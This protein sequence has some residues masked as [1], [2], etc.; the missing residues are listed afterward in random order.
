MKKSLVSLAVLPVVICLMTGCGAGAESKSSLHKMAVD[1]YVTPGD[2]TNLSVSAAPPEVEQ[3]QWDMLTLA[4]YQSYGS[5]AG[6]MDREVREGDT[7]N[8][9][10]EGRLDGIPF[11]RGADT[12]AQLTI[13]SGAFIDGFEDGLIGAVPGETRNL[14]LTFPEDFRGAE[15]AGKAVVFTVTVNYILPEWEDMKDSVVAAQEL[16]EAE[17]VEELKQFVYAYLLD[18]AERYYRYEVQDMLIEALMDTSEFAEVPETFVDSY[19][20][21]IA[22]DLAYLASNYD[23]TAEDFTNYYY[24]MGSEDYV[25]LYAEV[26]A[27]Q[28]ILLQAIAN[29]EG[30]GVDDKE[31]DALLEEYAEFLEYDSVEALLKDFDREEC[32]NYFMTEKVMDYLMEISEITE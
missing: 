20:E 32:R 13:G 7:V 18:N 27:R 21:G 12:D 24:N 30:L 9:D 26:Q 31:L 11:D 23:M 15:M 16:E 2:Y 6:I 1:E 5:S 4:V 10:Y 22:S 19:K 3:E 25:N 14:E 29:R 17:T 8:I 28:E